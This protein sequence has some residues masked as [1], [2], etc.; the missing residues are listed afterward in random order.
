[1][2]TCTSDVV[3]RRFQ[4]FRPAIGDQVI[5]QNFDKNNVQL[6]NGLINYNGDLLILKDVVINK[7]VNRIE[8]HIVNCRDD[9][10]KSINPF[11]PVTI[12]R[13]STGYTA[14]LEV[15]E[16]GEVTVFMYDLM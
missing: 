5:W 9:A 4:N 11:T 14:S 8:L 16:A 1:Y 10:A 13:S 15:K 12:V 7:S 3:I 2:N 6:Q